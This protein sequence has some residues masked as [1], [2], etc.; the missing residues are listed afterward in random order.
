LEWTLEP[1]DSSRFVIVDDS[2]IDDPAEALAP[3]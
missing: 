2:R 1:A 3:Y